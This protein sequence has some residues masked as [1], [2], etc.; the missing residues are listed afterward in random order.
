MK[1]QQINNTKYVNKTVNT[2]RNNR[3][4]KTEPM[5]NDSVNFKGAVS[6]RVFNIP[7]TRTGLKRILFGTGLSAAA[8]WAIKMGFDFIPFN[9][10]EITRPQLIKHKEIVDIPT[11]KK[12]DINNINMY[13]IPIL[14]D[15][16]E[17]S[18]LKG[19]EL[20]QYI[21]DKGIKLDDPS[22]TIISGS[23][24]SRIMSLAYVLPLEEGTKLTIDDKEII[25]PKGQVCLLRNKELTT[26]PFYQFHRKQWVLPREF[27]QEAEYMQFM[28]L[29]Y[30][31]E[32]GNVELADI[33][34][35]DGKQT[36]EEIYNKEGI[37]IKATGK[38]ISTK[39]YEYNNNGQLTKVYDS[40]K[41]IEYSYDKDKCIKTTKRY[42]NG[43][44]TIIDE[45]SNAARILGYKKD[46]LTV[47]ALNPEKDP[48]HDNI[49][50]SFS[51]T[52][53]AGILKE[54]NREYQVELEQNPKLNQYDVFIDIYDIGS[55]FR[56][57]YKPIITVKDKNTGNIISVKQG[58][59]K[60]KNH[61]GQTYFGLDCI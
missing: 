55:Y 56:H 1:I 60:D 31:N 58:Y 27:G 61:Q 12:L 32:D 21:K 46:N 13:D 52:E 29:P 48:I 47:M 50:D 19:D 3:Y 51:S 40:W 26:I 11:P 25:A 18:K 22:I 44:E 28:K 6:T 5:E 4:H 49:I 34:D 20:V 42:F 33:S 23:Y 37:L 24:D 43:F 54:I 16:E 39:N 45:D 41:I 9:E 36:K 59:F 35:Y 7:Q 2:E 14:Y 17:I 38:N 8:V 10:D 30:Y 15:K 53:V 57:A